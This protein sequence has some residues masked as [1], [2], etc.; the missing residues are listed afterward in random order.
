[1]RILR[2]GAFLGTVVMLCLGLAYGVAA[3]ALARA[4]AP[5]DPLL[6]LPDRV[7]APWWW[8]PRVG[9]SP[10]GAVSLAFAGRTMALDTPANDGNVALVS[11]GRDTYRMLEFDR[12]IAI[13]GESL[14]LSP[15]GGRVAHTRS[16][17][18]ARPGLSIV[19]LRTGTARHL[20]TDDQ[21]GYVDPL[22]W[23]PDGAALA[24]LRGRSGGVGEVG[25]VRLPGGEYR[26]IVGGLPVSRSPL[27]GFGVAFS[28]DGSRL[29]VERGAD[30]A[31][32]RVAD[33]AVESAVR[34]PEG[35]H[36]AGKG[37]WTPDGRALALVSGAQGRWR[38]RLVDP[39]TGA[40]LKRALPEVAD[41][42][43]LR[44][45]GW[46][47][48]GRALVVAYRRVPGTPPRLG[49]ERPGGATEYRYVRRVDLLALGFDGAA[50][51]VLALPGGVL[52]VDVPDA[53]VRSGAVRP[54]AGAPA[55]PVRPGL[56]VGAVVAALMLGGLVSVWLAGRRRDPD[57]PVGHRRPD[58]P[59]ER[60]T[61]VAP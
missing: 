21:Q 34:L 14:L 56:A 22:A 31:V 27:Y 55:W 53:V 1:M 38:V 41:A 29:A 5:D 44:L 33:G 11:G 47:S 45:L 58:R 50:T 18:P 60:M 51:R 54:G 26:G 6:A 43:A 17:D 59:M 13:P 7:S 15:D 23:A 35:A 16:L 9:Q 36:L 48:D 39:A 4:V 42:G 61:P 30:V 32:F 10:P 3:F 2:Q 57:L 52:A 28:P 46:R 37:A 8:T 12:A 24:V 49:I 40:D 25:V 19:D 20:L